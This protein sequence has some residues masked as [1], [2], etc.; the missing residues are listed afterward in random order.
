MKDSKK[1]QRQ[2]LN[3]FLRGQAKETKRERDVGINVRVTPEEKRHITLLA[4]AVGLTVSELLRQLSCGVQVRA[5]PPRAFYDLRDDLS[6]LCAEVRRKM[7]NGA[8]FSG[9]LTSIEASLNTFRQVTE[10]FC[11]KDGER[12]YAAYRAGDLWEDANGND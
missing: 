6:V 3:R 12:E 7:Q 4:H 11:G 10:K 2:A 8:D 5:I 1:E 9:E